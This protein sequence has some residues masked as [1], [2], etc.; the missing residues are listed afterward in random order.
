MA[1]SQNVLPTLE[2]NG[3]FEGRQTYLCKDEDDD[4]MARFVD[5]NEPCPLQSIQLFLQQR[6][7]KPVSEEEATE[8]VTASLEI[9]L[10]AELAAALLEEAIRVR[11]MLAFLRASM[12]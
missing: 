12:N 10:R 8:A 4:D 5:D 1:D 7:G 3:S 9:R 2:V 11:L 6:T